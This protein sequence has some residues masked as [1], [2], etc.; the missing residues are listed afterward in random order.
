MQKTF[1]LGL[2]AQKAGTTWLYKH[3]HNHPQCAL[4]NVKE[5]AALD[6][7]FGR[8][9]NNLR[10][11]KRIAA[12]TSALENAPKQLEKGIA[13]DKRVHT[14]LESFEYL[15]SCTDLDA[16]VRYFERQL[17]AKPGAHVVADITPAYCMLSEDNL[18]E[19]KEALEAAG[20]AVRVVFLMRDPV[21]RCYSAFRMAF[22]RDRR[23]GVEALRQ[24]N[25]DFVRRASASGCQ[26]RTRYEKIVP[27]IDAVFTPEERFIGFYEEFFSDQSLQRLC[28]V[29]GINHVSAKLDKRVNTSPREVEPSAE[30]WAQ[31]RELYSDTYAYCSERFGAEKVAELWSGQS[32]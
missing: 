26:R 31:V 18:R 22:R 23:A 3:M 11:E 12:V 16:Y 24:P 20:F 27:R 30:D 9:F 8:E 14:L 13:D 19:T 5:L 1:V 15:A 21:E 10:W 6:M 29:L 25:A 17:A 4:G 2:G 32:K 28:D 7:Y